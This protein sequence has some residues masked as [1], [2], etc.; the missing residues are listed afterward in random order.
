M[1]ITVFA[2]ILFLA[3][4]FGVSIGIYQNHLGGRYS[5]APWL[6]RDI[7]EFNGLKAQR[8]TFQSAD[9]QELVGY[10]YSKD[11]LTI[12]GTA[13][14]GIIVISHGYGNG[15]QNLYMDVADFFTDHGYLVFAYDSTGNGESEGKS[16]RGIP[17]GVMDL[18]YAVQYL[19][20]QKEFDDFPIM[21]FGHSVG[22]YS[23][24]SVLNIHPDINA[25]VMVAGFNQ[26]RDLIKEEMEKVSRPLSALLPWFA[27]FERV[28]F[29]TYSSY[30]CIGGF[31][32]S[33]AGVMV[34]H[35]QDDEN[36]SFEDQYLMF[37]NEYRNDPRFTFA[38]FTDRGHD[39]VYY[40]DRHRE[41]RDSFNKRFATYVESLNGPFTAEIKAEYMQA[42]LDKAQLFDLDQEL[43]EQ[44]LLFY[45]HHL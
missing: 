5:V 8:H 3:I 7:G 34:I 2:A 6:K 18:D 16:V 14:K 31:E 43:F 41:Y 13:S 10:A 20:S 45:D 25:V 44:I 19:K 38:P 15:G 36:I 12:E 40:S 9:N 27:L 1:A 30:S 11:H 33:N 24:G 23:A 42:H 35:S 26:S 17:Q 29:G 28:K 21:I 4:P 37:H 22:A 32:N 39:Y